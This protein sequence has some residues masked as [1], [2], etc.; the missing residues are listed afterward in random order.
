MGQKKRTKDPDQ[1]PVVKELAGLKPKMSEWQVS[2]AASLVQNYNKW[3]R[4]TPKQ[5]NCVEEMVKQLKSGQSGPAQIPILE[6]VQVSNIKAMF[7]KA[8]T[9]LNRMAVTL[10]TST[11]GQSV[12]FRGAGKNSKWHGTIFIDVEVQG[13]QLAVGRINTKGQLESNKLNLSEWDGVRLL[14]KAFNDNPEQV[15]RTHGTTTGKCCFC[16]KGLNDSRSLDVGYGPICAG[17][18]GLAWGA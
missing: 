11:S 14:V 3:G 6:D 7:D 18:Y 2:F 13:S 10:R 9:K 4:L 1:Y 17:N 8:A 5:F 15:A 16:R 12:T